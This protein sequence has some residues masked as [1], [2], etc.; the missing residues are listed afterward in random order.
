MIVDAV[1]A[2]IKAAVR[3]LL[4]LLPVWSPLNIGD[5]VTGMLN[6]SGPFW[7]LLGWLNNYIPVREAVAMIGL[8]VTLYVAGMAWD[9]LIWVL[10]K[11]HIAG[12]D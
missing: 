12:G 3:V 4:E 2:L 6:I 10:T 1:F 5:A 11:L 8:L 7:T 9:L